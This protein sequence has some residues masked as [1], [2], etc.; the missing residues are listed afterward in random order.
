MFGSVVAAA[1]TECAKSLRRNQIKRMRNKAQTLEH[2]TIELSAMSL[3]AKPAAQSQKPQKQRRRKQDH[4]E[5]GF[6]K[7]TEACLNSI[8]CA[9][10]REVNDQATPFYAEV[11]VAA[12]PIEPIQS[13]S[14]LLNSESETFEVASSQSLQPASVT[15]IP[16]E[17]DNDDSVKEDTPN[18]QFLIS[19]YWEDD[20]YEASF[21]RENLLDVPIG[22][23]KPDECGGL[24]DQVLGMG[25]GNGVCYEYVD[26]IAFVREIPSPAL[27]RVE[28]L[29]PVSGSKTRQYLT[30]S[31]DLIKR[32]SSA[33]KSLESFDEVAEAVDIEKVLPSRENTTP[34]L[35][36]PPDIRTPHNAYIAATEDAFIQQQ[37]KPVE[38]EVFIFPKLDHPAPFP[39]SIETPRAVEPEHFLDIEGTSFI[40]PKALHTKVPHRKPASRAT[41]ASRRVPNTV[42][43]E[44][45]PRDIP[46]HPHSPISRSSPVERLPQLK[47]F[48]QSY[49]HHVTSESHAASIGK[50]PVSVNNCY[51]DGSSASKESGSTASQHC[52]INNT[53]TIHRWQLDMKKKLGDESKHEVSD[54][55]RG[56]AGSVASIQPS[57][58]AFGF[59]LK[60]VAQISASSIGAVKK[61]RRDGVWG[62][63][64]KR[65]TG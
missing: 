41:S 6:R 27:D 32:S 23:W 8:S 31:K 60:P 48:S 51:F 62:Y 17:R 1:D 29:R 52:S 35:E 43:H 42:K 59:S 50:K 65:R 12:E 4:A 30:P 63:G 10:S 25:I 9:M 61:T 2:T 15:S 47:L 14:S 33:V 28:L 22:P 49:L 3:T 55:M 58:G 13:A 40:L 11:A 45:S 26:P 34:S 38:P 18:Q 39:L 54:N 44:P 16:M 37:S 46:S 64:G 21:Y 56:S 5:H 19:L 53:I 24:I 7:N 57:L 20:A 36:Q